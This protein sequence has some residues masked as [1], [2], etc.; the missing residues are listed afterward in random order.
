MNSYETPSVKLEYGMDSIFIKTF[1]TGLTGLTGYFHSW[2]PE[3]TKK[4]SSAC[5]GKRPE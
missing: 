1:L 4:T 5:G 3:E 2:F